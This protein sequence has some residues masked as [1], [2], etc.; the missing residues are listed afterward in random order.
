MREAA[1]VLKIGGCLAGFLLGFYIVGMVAGVIFELDGASGFDL[2]PF[3]AMWL[4]LGAFCGIFGFMTAG[5]I[6]YPAKTG[7]DWINQEDAKPAGWLVFKTTTGL[8]LGL[9]A[10]L[11]VFVWRQDVEVNSFLP[12]NM[13]MLLTFFL[14]V[15]AA[16]WLGYNMTGP[17]RP[18]KRAPTPGASKSQPKLPD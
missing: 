10:L 13:P 17:N 7:G 18:G 16:S 2:A 4:V 8:L 14:T 3:F 5:G 6:A 1:R 15:G 12:D 11:Y 9:S